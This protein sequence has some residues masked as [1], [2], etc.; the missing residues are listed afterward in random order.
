METKEKQN[1]KGQIV[2]SKK[3]REKSFLFKNWLK[4]GKIE[5]GFEHNAAES[6]FVAKRMSENFSS[7]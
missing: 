1:Q 3:A 6:R 7:F 5:F 2:G 4:R